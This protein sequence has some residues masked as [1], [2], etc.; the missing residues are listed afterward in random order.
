MLVYVDDILHIAEDPKVDMALIN[1]IYRLKEGVGPPDRYLGGSM[2]R[3]QLQ[4]GSV[5]WSMNCVEYL[6]G[7]ISNVDKY[8]NECDSALKNYGTARGLIRRL[9]ALKWM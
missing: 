3:V 4:D 2:E 9:T 1:S 6:Q 5:A 8:L 7:A